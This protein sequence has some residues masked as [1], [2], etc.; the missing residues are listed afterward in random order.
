MTSSISARA[1][2]ERLNKVGKDGVIRESDVDVLSIGLL[3]AFR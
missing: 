1:E 2:W 3:Y